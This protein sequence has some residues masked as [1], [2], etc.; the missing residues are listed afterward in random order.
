MLPTKI[1]YTALS[2]GIPLGSFV[3]LFFVISVINKRTDWFLLSTILGIATKSNNDSKKASKCEPPENN[4]TVSRKQDGKKED[5]KNKSIQ[6]LVTCKQCEMD[7]AVTVGKDEAVTPFEKYLFIEFGDGEVA[8][9]ELKCFIRFLSDLMAAAI[10]G[11]FVSI[12]VVKLILSNEL[13]KNGSKCPKYSADCFSNDG[14]NDYSPYS[15]VDGQYLN[16][17]GYTGLAWCVGWVYKDK[18]AQ[19]V[20]DALGTCGGL[21][22]IVSCIFPLVYYMPYYKKYHWG[23]CL[24]IILPIGGALG[25]ALT[26]WATWD[27]GLSQLGTTV[28]IV[29]VIMI[30]IGWSWALWRSCVTNQSA[31]VFH[32]LHISIEKDVQESAVTTDG[33][34]VW[35]IF[36]VNSMN[37]IH[38]PTY[39][40]FGNT[41]AVCVA[42]R[43]IAYIITA[44]QL[45][46]Q[47][48]PKCHHQKVL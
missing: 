21:L 10:L 4:S 12:I 19:D 33:V 16:I 28:F 7:V 9:P 42:R 13:V 40:I 47:Q 17:T 41:Y 36:F 34:F 43:I 3:L 5:E 26:L 18:S 38:G 37:G 25:L 14:R 32:I 31:H 11:I 2:W 6:N 20:L 24:C 46:K 39:G 23:S 29:L 44:Q 27:D 8:V 30:V 48:N 45:A 35:F 1:N 15:C 22:G